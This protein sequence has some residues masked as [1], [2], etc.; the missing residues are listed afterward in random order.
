MEKQ[1]TGFVASLIITAVLI[2]LTTFLFFYLT[3]PASRGTNFYVSYGYLVFL[4]LVEGI[5]LSLVY[6]SRAELRT[7]GMWDFFFILGVIIS[8]FVVL[9][10]LS[11]IVFAVLNLLVSGS[12]ALVTTVAIELSLFVLVAALAYFLKA[13]SETMD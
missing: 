12:K 4:E 8:F 7:K 13:K 10:L 11:I 2:G 1:K 5:Y 3:S 6:T 9:G